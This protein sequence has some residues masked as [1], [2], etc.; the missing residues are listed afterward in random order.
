[1][2]RR[3]GLI[4]GMSDAGEQSPLRAVTDLISAVVGT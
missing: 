4:V 1:M 2:T 3:C